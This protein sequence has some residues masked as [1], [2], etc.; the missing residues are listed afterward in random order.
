MTTVK[1]NSW[2]YALEAVKAALPNTAEV[3]EVFESPSFTQHVNDVICD[4]DSD[5]SFK[6]ALE[7]KSDPSLI[8]GKM[9]L[10]VIGQHR[11]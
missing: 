11:D 8:T 1:S 6:C 9:L 7:P 10:L 3:E 4:E 5:A 2:K